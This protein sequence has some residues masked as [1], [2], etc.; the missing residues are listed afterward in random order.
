MTITRTSCR[1]A[2]IC[3][4]IVAMPSVL[5]SGQP[6]TERSGEQTEH[7]GE[8]GVRLIYRF[9]PNQFLHYEVEH[10]MTIDIRFE[11]GMM[12]TSNTSKTKKHFRVISVDDQGHALVEAVIDHVQMSAQADGGDPVAFDSAD[13]A[14]KCPPEYR[15]VMKTVGKPLSRAEF[16][17]NGKLINMTSTKN[18]DGRVEPASAT[19]ESN[20][21]QSYLVE[22]PDR[23]LHVGDT[24]KEKFEVAVVIP[25]SRLQRRISCQRSFRLDS[26]EGDLA[27]ITVKTTVLTPIHDPQLRVQL[28]QKSPTGSIVFDHR[29][30]VLVSR[31][32]KTDKTEIDGIGPKT[33]MHAMSERTER[34]V[35]TP[36]VAS[37][38]DN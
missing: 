7:S 35:D 17:P 29:R 14:D 32:I 31:M 19:E 21:P 11:Q 26:V 2:L 22:F 34:L 13:G 1:F 36:A 5:Q 10:N 25:A 9:Q 38:K 8:Q 27:T 30:G 33:S 20:A 37:T 4:A 24:W 16:T 28:I 6:T 23:E 12:K 18:G 15:H 3:A